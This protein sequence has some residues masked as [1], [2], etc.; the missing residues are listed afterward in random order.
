M[1][2]SLYKASMEGNIGVLMQNKDRFKEQVTPANNTVL[3][4][5][6]QL[7]VEEDK[8]FSHG[9]NN[10]GET[11]LPCSR[12]RLPRNCVHNLDNL[13]VTGFQWPKW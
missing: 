1:D 10:S 4:I 11:A 12:E 3:H 5:T 6:A 9:A 8:G 7:L 2:P 13:Y